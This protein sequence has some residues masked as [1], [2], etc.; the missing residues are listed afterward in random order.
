MKNLQDLTVIILTYNTQEKILFEC[1]GSID[2]NVNILIVENSNDFKHK[3][4]VIKNFPNT[5]VICSGENLGYGKGNN[6]G[7]KHVSTDYILILNP[8]V[9]CDQNFFSNILDVVNEAKDFSI[10]GC[11]Y[12]KDKIFMPA[13][14]FNRKKK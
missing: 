12:L 4:L 6:F 7:I 3:N 10:I 5:K 14:F 2:K 11:Q 1:L 9:I 13:G 8:D